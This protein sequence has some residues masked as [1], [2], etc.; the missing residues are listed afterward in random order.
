FL[1]MIPFEISDIYPASHYVLTRTE[2]RPEDFPIFEKTWNTFFAKNQFVAIHCNKNDK[3]IQSFVKS[4]PS[5]I[6]IKNLN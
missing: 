2:F 1:G 4:L 3:F 6:K 5:R